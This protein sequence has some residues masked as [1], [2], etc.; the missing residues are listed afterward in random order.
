MYYNTL[1]NMLLSLN[2]I[3]YD[4]KISRNAFGRKNMYKI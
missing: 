3:Q 4:E 1:K 2:I